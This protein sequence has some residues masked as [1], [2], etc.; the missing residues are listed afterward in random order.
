MECLSNYDP[1]FIADAVF[2]SDPILVNDDGSTTI[3]QYFDDFYKLC[4]QLLDQFF[5]TS[6]VTITS[7]DPPYITPQIK[8]MLKTKNKLMRR[9]KIEKANSIAD[10]IKA[11]V[12]SRN[13]SSFSH[14]PVK[15]SKDLWARV[16]ALSGKNNKNHA[17]AISNID[18]E[19]LKVHYAAISTDK[20]YQPPA[21]K[22]TVNRTVEHL[23]EFRVFGLLD[24]LKPTA[25]GLDCLPS[26][27]LRL[28]APFLAK[29][30]TTLY[31]L[32]L[33]W[34]V[35]P[36][37]WKS[38]VITPVPKISR[39]VSCSDYRP[40]SV[41][42]ILSRLLE[43]SLVQKFIY[44]IFVHPR[45]SHLFMDQ[46]AFRPTGSTTAAL[47][48]LVHIIADLL[49]TY[50]YVHL[51][52]L[53]FSK[54]FDTV[55]HSTLMV[56]FS[57]LHI[58]DCIY[59]WITNFLLN[60][61][62]CTK[63]N[64]NL[65]AKARINASI[66][67]GTTTGPGSYTVNASDLHPCY[68]ENRLNKYADDSY[69]I[70]P[71]INSHLVREELDHIEEWAG[72]NNLNLNASKSK[73]MIIRRPQFNQA[74]LPHPIPGIERVDSMNILGVILRCDLS[75]HEQ[76]E[77]LASQSAQTMDALRM[78]RSQGLSDPNLWEVAEATL[79]SRLSYASQVW[80][81]MIRESE[82]L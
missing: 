76:V 69:L 32:S 37:Q 64:G 26:W 17:G 25:Q 63:F 73:K 7:K 77:R 27:F 28:A 71:S 74:A 22:Q 42:P 49:Q 18:A 36:T 57:N 80:W 10:R 8:Y 53:D 4:T 61:D 43:K 70:V 40:I 13:A 75:F 45:S 51:I 11:H 21:M 82:R 19:K 6:T 47:I 15:N 44:P 38:S 2:H 24:S 39:P 58:P 16:R 66:V 3:Q 65:S 59:N 41:T 52:A 72:E 12:M 14:N 23:T 1:N 54:A 33:S 20:Q 9:G 34:S 55:R 31:N 30:L 67:Q 56:K 35:V 5:P 60:R 68:P 81:G 29:P 62:H 78:L 48:N 50:P 46:F 79:V